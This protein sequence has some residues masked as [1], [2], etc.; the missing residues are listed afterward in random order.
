MKENVLGVDVT[1]LGYEELSQQLLHD[2][3]QGKKVFLVAINPEKILK[4][5]KD[6][7][8][9][10][11]LNSADYQIPDGMG[12][13]IASKSQKGNIKERVTGIDMMMKICETSQKEH[14]RV[15]LYGA[16]PGVADT[17]KA[18]LEEKYPGISIVGTL[19]GYEK[20]EE[21]VISI[22]NESKADVLFVALGSPRQENWIVKNR[23]KL[24]PCI[25]QGVGG[26]YDVI[27]G[28]IPRAPKW[29]QNAGLEWL[30]RLLKE[31]SRFKRYI[32]LFS[33]ISL[34]GQEK[35]KRK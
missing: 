32:P 15:F 8:L 20:D 31:P 28:N 33:F 30:Y 7:E 24:H 25:F 10:S 21:K 4:A 27:S 12:V 11:L 35:I 5:R 3:K 1:T 14:L 16:K 18:K 29:M 19:D 17:A 23:H 34:V 2:H 22:I 13:V 9:M 26:S 6:P